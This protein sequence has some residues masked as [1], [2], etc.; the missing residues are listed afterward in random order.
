MLISLIVI[1]NSQCILMSKHH[2][3][4]LLHTQIYTIFIFELYSSKA[5]KN[6]I[7]QNY[8]ICMNVFNLNN[9]CSYI[10]TQMSR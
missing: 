9:K 10:L 6:D 5:G 7:I 2:L 8:F 3:V 1:I 4:H